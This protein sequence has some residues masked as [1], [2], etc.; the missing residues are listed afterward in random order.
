MRSAYGA[1]LKRAQNFIHLIRNKRIQQKP[2]RGMNVWNH[3]G[4]FCNII[5]TILRGKNKRA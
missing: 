3:H 5:K 1:F 2:Q 4:G